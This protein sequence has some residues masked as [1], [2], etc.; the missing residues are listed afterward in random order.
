VEDRLIK[1]AMEYASYGW[2]IVPVKPR[3]KIPIAGKEWQYKASK[4]E[5]QIESWWGQTPLAN[6]GV[7]LGEKSG[8]VDFE[9]DGPKAE[10]TMKLLFGDDIPI[11]PT[12]RSS[13]GIHRILKYRNDLPEPGKNLFKIGDLEIRTGNSGKGAQSVFPPSV[14]ESGKIY[15][16]L[17]HPSEIEPAIIPND[18]LAKL[19]NWAGSKLDEMASFSTKAKPD[20]YWAKIAEGVDAGERNEKAAEYIGRLLRDIADPFDNSSIERL[21]VLILAWNNDRNS[22]PLEHKELSTI[23]QSIVQRHRQSITDE[24]FEEEFVREKAGSA[25][26]W[27]LII[28]KSQPRTYRLYSPLWSHKARNGY[29]ELTT[30]QMHSADAVRRQA[31]E[32]ADVW[33]TGAFKKLWNGDKGNESLARKLVE[34]AEFV[35]SALEGRRDL[36]AAEYLHETLIRADVITADLDVSTMGKPQRQDDGSILF[37][38]YAVWAWPSESAD[39]IKRKEMADLLDEIGVT[40]VQRRVSGK[41]MRFKHIDIDGMRRLENMI[42]LAKELKNEFDVH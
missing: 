24:H 7:L 1:S 11:T 27:R 16:W 17:I 4:E 38:F 29:I 9:G 5:F 41:K 8:I 2:C 3:G 10:Q 33:V 26:D 37:K 20:D 14:H 40:N 13:R 42:G 28:V 18:V 25:G 31:L 15:E 35:E 34:T 19:W 12:Y 39:K 6:V 23:Y 32:Q 36:V 30:E 22:P 21:W